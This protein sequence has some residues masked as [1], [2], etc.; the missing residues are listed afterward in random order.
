MA[1][2]IR[3]RLRR[4]ARRDSGRILTEKGRG[5]EE[6]SLEEGSDGSTVLGKFDKALES[7]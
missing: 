7:S 2:G 3:W 1:G 6:S 4:P 5:D